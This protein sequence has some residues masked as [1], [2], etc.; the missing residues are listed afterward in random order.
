[1]QVPLRLQ[2]CAIKFTGRNWPQKFSLKPHQA[3]VSK[4]FS[5][6]MYG[7]IAVFKKYHKQKMLAPDKESYCFVISSKIKL[8]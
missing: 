5:L 4:P 2:I 1:M 6:G 7:K 3:K 8:I